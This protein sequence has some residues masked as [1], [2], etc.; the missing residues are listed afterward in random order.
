[1]KQVEFQRIGYEETITTRYDSRC[2]CSQLFQRSFHSPPNNNLLYTAQLNGFPTTVRHAGPIFCSDSRGHKSRT[3]VGACRA[4]V[5]R[6]HAC[7]SKRNGR[8]KDLESYC[9]ATFSPMNGYIDI[10]MNTVYT[11][12][13]SSTYDMWPST[14]N[15]RFYPASS[16]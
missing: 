16:P 14:I 10:S 8:P 7:E 5:R 15:H 9:R 6:F 1:M 12:D 4:N 3:C 13:T 11:V 2:V